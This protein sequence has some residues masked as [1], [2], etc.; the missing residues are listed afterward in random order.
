MAPIKDGRFDTIPPDERRETRRK[1][2]S[3]NVGMRTEHGFW[4]GFAENIS[5]GGIFIATHA[6]FDIGEK[7][8]LSF[9]LAKKGGKKV[10]SVACEVRWIR[11]DS[12]GGLPPGMGLKFLDLAPGVSAEIQEHIER[13]ALD[14]LFMDVDD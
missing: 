6:P 11:P 2:V 10:F 5:E 14:V 3:V 1:R 13:G 8:D 4:N 9:A 7:V 12:G